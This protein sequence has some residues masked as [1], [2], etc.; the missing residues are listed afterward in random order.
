MIEK[1]PEFLQEELAMGA[2]EVIAEMMEKTGVNRAELAKRLDSSKSNITQTLR[3][4]R[5][6]TVKNLAKIA[7]VLGYRI[8]IDAVPF[9]ADTILAGSCTTRI[10]SRKVVSVTDVG[11]ASR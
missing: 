9:N 6:L 3:G 10:Q 4:S 11:K 2:T 7:A 1:R 5:N 8:E